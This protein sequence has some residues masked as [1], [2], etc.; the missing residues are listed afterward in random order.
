[1]S[2]IERLTI[3][4][5]KQMAADI[6]DV[7]AGGEY[8]S[9]S[10]VIH[11]ALRDWKARRAARLQDLTMLKAEI[12]RGLADVATGRVEDF[13]ASRVIDRGRTLSGGRSPSV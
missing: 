2:E 9:T 12:G 13:N 10:E 5:P 4:L 8:A 6:Q 1:L 11:E 7:V 3:T